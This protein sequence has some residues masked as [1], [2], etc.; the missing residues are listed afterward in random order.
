MWW[1]AMTINRKNVRNPCKSP[2]IRSLLQ[3]KSVLVL[4]LGNI[5]LRDE[6]VGIRVINSLEQE[7]FE[8]ADLLDGGTGGFHLL[9]TLQSYKTVILVDASLDAFPAGHVRILQPKYA[10]DFPKQL[11]AHEFGLR[12]LMDSARVLGCL[13][14]IYL[15]AISVK[16]FQDIGMELSP[17]I[18]SAI[19]EAI[20][21]INAI[22]RSLH[23]ASGTH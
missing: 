21:R 11:S 23:P 8:G 19:P 5:L 17:E 1:N 10:E 20:Q 16:D 12:D 18:E 9:D 22:I 4:G 7:E 3:K 15:V 13:P 2:V 14:E 6:G